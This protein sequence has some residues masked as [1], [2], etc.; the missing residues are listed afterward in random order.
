[1]SRKPWPTR[2]ALW[3]AVCALL[4]KAAVPMLASV[5]AQAQ[6]KALV[7]VCTVYGVATVALDG[8]GSQSTPEHGG[9]SH[10]DDHCAL[11]ALMALGTPEPST[12]VAVAPVSLA[13]SPP[14]VP[15]SS[16]APD[17]S[18]LWVAGLQHGP[19]ALV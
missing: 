1:M 3:V 10:A 8:S 17:A 11:T 6:G 2:F 15:T 16:E 4:L 12:Q 18:A 14:P 5:S 13:D 9:A 19:P 7:E